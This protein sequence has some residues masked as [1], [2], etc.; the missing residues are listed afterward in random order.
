MQWIEDTNS[1]KALYG[2]PGI[3]SLRKVADRLMPLYRQSVMTPRFCVLTTVGDTGVV[4]RPRSGD[5][6]FVT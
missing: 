2:A 6:P 5:G 3:P 4:E 1:L